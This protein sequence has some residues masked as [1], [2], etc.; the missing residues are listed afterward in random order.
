M[1][2]MALR[3]MG[4]VLHIQSGVLAK[5]AFIAGRR[6]GLSF[7]LIFFDQIGAAVQDGMRSVMAQVQK[8]RL[9]SSLK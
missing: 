8:E 3:P 2:I 6:G 5:I 4:A 9:S 1:W 7:F